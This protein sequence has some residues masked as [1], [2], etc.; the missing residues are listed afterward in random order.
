M[1]FMTYKIEDFLMKNPTDEYS[2]LIRELSYIV[3][4]VLYK[5]LSY[6]YKENMGEK[7]T[8]RSDKK[9]LAYYFNH[10]KYNANKI[11]SAVLSCIFLILSVVCL[12]FIV[13]VMFRGSN[14][15]IIFLFIQFALIVLGLLFCSRINFY[16]KLDF[17]NYVDAYVYY[18]NNHIFDN[19][20]TVAKLT[21]QILEE[22]QNNKG[23]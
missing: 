18:I 2:R 23:V 17:L 19:D 15:N 5:N 22:I 4:E 12:S 10:E 6:A 11:I 8:Y 21:D 13:S 7:F 20:S 1:H 14:T 9:L 3:D 16:M